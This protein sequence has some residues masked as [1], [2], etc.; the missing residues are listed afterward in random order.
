MGLKAEKWA[1]CHSPS[2]CMQWDSKHKTTYIHTH[3]YQPHLRQPLAS[4]VSAKARAG[5]NH[6]EA[7]P[8]TLA[9]RC[10]SGGP[11]HRPR[12][13]A[14]T[15]DPQFIRFVCYIYLH[16]IQRSRVALRLLSRPVNSG[17]QEEILLHRGS[18]LTNR[19]R[20]RCGLKRGETAEI[21]RWEEFKE[22]R[23][24][25]HVEKKEEALRTAREWTESNQMDTVWTDGSRLEDKKVGAAVAFKSRSGWKQ[26]GIYLGR[27]KEVFDAEVFAIREALRVLNRRGEAGKRYTIFSD[28]QAALSRIQ[29]DRTGPG[30]TLAI[31]AITTAGEIVSRGN[32]IC[33]RWTPSHEGIEGNERADQMARRAA[34]GR[35]GIAGPEYLS[36]ASLSHL[37]RVTTE[38]RSN[39]TAEWIRKRSGRHRRYQPPKGGKMRKELGKARKE[40]ASRFYQLL[41]GHAAVAR[42]L[43]R[44]RQIE[45]DRC[46]WCGSGAIQ[47]RHHLFIVCRRWGPEIKRLWQKVRLETGWGGAPSIRRLFGD[48]RN[49][50]AILE[51]LETTKVGKMPSRVLL[52]GGPDLE[53]E[54]LEGFSLQVL[55]EEVETEVSS[56]GDEDGPGPPI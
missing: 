3:A 32:N 28:S 38:N 19:I 5:S 33:L 7:T 16:D 47:T 24:E 6:G 4:R 9:S 45:D 53:E 46:F 35:E 29:H 12:E 42:H 18:E 20:S 8:L 23:A 31:D 55:G 56:S 44:I 40:L 34:E 36:E 43:Q 41:S 27:N 51:F 54:E 50:K 1:R 49:M 39:A 30:Q 26:E 13:C 25:V 15:P 22:L 21:Q 48:E 17:G 2:G 52:A 14:T 10:G 37:T 11:L